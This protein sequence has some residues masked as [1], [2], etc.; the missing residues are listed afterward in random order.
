MAFLSYKP[1]LLLVALAYPA[2]ASADT[3][4]LRDGA[5]VRGELLSIRG[6]VVEFE[7]TNGEG[8][9]RTVRV[10]REQVARIEFDDGQSGDS[11]DLWG[12]SSRQ[13]DPASRQADTPSAGMRE[14]VVEVSASQPWS[15]TGIAL[16]SGQTIY[17]Q[18]TGQV[19][20]GRDRR[21]GPDGEDDSP[22]NAARPIP[23]R[24]AAALIGRV[25]QDQTEVFFIGAETS[26]IR[27]RR[28]GRLYLGIN[29]EYLEDNNGSFR[30][31]IRY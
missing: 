15:D 4:V 11:F 14:R 25:G 30:V 28:S 3:L 17:L 16:R 24:P 7:E 1:A 19:R 8:R 10:D 2:V 27:V 13:R 12:D 26:P 20:W 9:R 29:D 21:D 18:A 22:Y 23:N 5:R 31:L 6:S